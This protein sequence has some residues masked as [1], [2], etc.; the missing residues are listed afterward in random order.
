VSTHP[1]SI[2]KHLSKTDFALFEGALTARSFVHG[3]LVAEAG[4]PIDQVYFP[5]S[6]LISIVVPLKNGEVIEAGIVG[7]QDVFGVAAAFGAKTHVN[8]AVAQMPG[9]FSVMKAADLINAT[10]KS[11]TL[12]RDLFLHDQFMLA[13][14][15]QLAACNA[16]H[17]ITQR[18]AALLLRVRDRAQQEEL[19]LTQEFLGQMLGVQRASVSIAA[20]AMQEAGM[21]QY[22]RGS[23]HITD[24]PKL[25]QTACECYGVLRAQYARTFP[26]HAPPE[27]VA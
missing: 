3:E 16:R 17:D 19:A 12:R 13:Q 7:R 18:L 22:R 4:S 20:G 6:G 1:N 25:E 27:L 2:L 9:S 26:A 11:E 8:R 21:I 14:A 15:Q 24:T 5:N 23:I 10:N